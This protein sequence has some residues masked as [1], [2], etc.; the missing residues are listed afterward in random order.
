MATTEQAT[1]APNQ[2]H[3]QGG[4]I[5]VSYFPEGS[6]PPIKDRGRLRF[7]YQDSSRSLAFYGNEVR[8]VDVPDLGTVVSVTIVQTIDIGSTSASL[9]VPLV[10]LPESHPS[11]QIHTDLITTIHRFFVSAIGHPQHEVYSVTALDGVAGS[12]PLPL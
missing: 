1:T 8:T 4:C 9:L 10:V 6:G 3:L 5:S 11:A 12:A 2:Y 7:T